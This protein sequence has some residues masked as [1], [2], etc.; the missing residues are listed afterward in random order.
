MFFDPQ[1]D[2][3]LPRDKRKVFLEPFVLLDDT[4]RILH[5][6]ADNVDVINL[7]K[8]VENVLTVFNNGR[9]AEEARCQMYS[10]ARSNASISGIPLTSSADLLLPVCFSSS[11]RYCS[12]T[13]ARTPSISTALVF[14]RVSIEMSAARICHGSIESSG[15]WLIKAECKRM[16]DE[17]ELSRLT[18]PDLA[19]SLLRRP[20]GFSFQDRKEI[21]S[22]ARAAT[23]RDW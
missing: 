18:L 8:T 17:L 11:A 14:M 6:R 12:N 23:N 4:I 19:Q 16:P 3:L 13:L 9:I 20:R 22:G 21:C 5:R 1:K 10:L 7:V 2:Y 15:V